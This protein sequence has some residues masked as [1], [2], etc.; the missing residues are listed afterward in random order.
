AD[1][2]E[3]CAPP[4]AFRHLLTLTPDAREFADGVGRQRVSGNLDTPEGGFDAIM[5]VALC[6]EHIGWRSVTRLLV[7]ASDDAFHTAGDGKL[8]GIVLPSD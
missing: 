4:V 1:P 3:F 6:Q 8:G 5:Q 7:F 2:R